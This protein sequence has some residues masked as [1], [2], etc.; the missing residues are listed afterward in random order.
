MSGRCARMG[1]KRQRERVIQ[2]R[3]VD[4]SHRYDGLRRRRRRLPRRNPPWTM[5]EKGLLVVDIV[6]SV[7][8]AALIAERFLL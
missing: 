2:A 4:R 7:G 5:G 1:P 8:V 3:V 6:Y